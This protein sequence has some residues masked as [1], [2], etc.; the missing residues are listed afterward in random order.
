MLTDILKFFARFPAKTAI[1]SMFSANDSGISDYAALKTDIIAEA[2]EL[3]SDIKKFIFSQ[4]ENTI[5]EIVDKTDGYLMMVEY[6]PIRT[7]SPNAVGVR[8]S[9]FG[10]SVI[11]AHHLFTRKYDTAAEILVMD[12]CLTFLKQVFTEMKRVDDDEDTCHL[13]NW[14]RGNVDF[15]PIEPQALYQAVGW[16]MTITYSSNLAF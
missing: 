5:R 15:S 7:S 11:V 9:G 3:I 16:N 8:E 13:V 2:D 14:T 10:L 6:G 1:E 12:Q 4:N